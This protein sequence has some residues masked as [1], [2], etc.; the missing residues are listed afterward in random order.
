MNLTESI[1]NARRILVKIGS[2]T[3][4]DE[5]KDFNL[6]VA[7]ALARQIKNL[8]ESGKRFAIISSG[9]LALGSKGTNGK[10]REVLAAIGQH[11]LISGWKRTFKKYAITTL[12]ALI[13]DG[14]TF[15]VNV[16]AN[17]N[18]IWVINGNDIITEKDNDTLA[19]ELTR[20]VKPDLLIFL[21]NIS[22][23]LDSNQKVMPAIKISDIDFRIC[24]KEKSIYGKGGME[25]KL[26][27]LH[28]M[29]PKIALIA[30]G[31]EE[32]ILHKIFA[33]ENT[34]TVLYKS[35]D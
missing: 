2:N 8:T 21:S 34:G 10:R 19:S 16:F 15:N 7:D 23:V 31:K 14:T 17:H 33:C 32:N 27:S 28:Q 20:S 18:E 4:V 6:E 11:E 1:K 26:K 25:S 24:T 22:G 30:N 12:P 35:M 13:T 5:N 9:A 29:Y 3:I